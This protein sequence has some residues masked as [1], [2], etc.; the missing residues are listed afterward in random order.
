MPDTI[1]SVT[2][3]EN[4]LLAEAQ[5]IA[6]RLLEPN[7]ERVDRSGTVPFENLEALAAAGLVDGA[8]QSEAFRKA[9][10]EILCAAC[11]T[12]YFVLTQHLGSCGQIQQSAN[13]WL[14][15][16]FGVA[17]ATG[18]HYVGVGFGHLRRP[19]PML[20]ATP[21][22]GGWTLTG[23]APWVTGWPVLSGT[24]YG[25]HLPDGRHLYVYADA[26]VS[27]QQRISAPLPLCAMGATETVEV[28]LDQLFVPEENFVRYS[29]A[30]QLALSDT[31]N[32]CGNVSPMLGVARGSVSLLR[33][34]A[35]KK[36]FP[37]LHEAATA[38]ESQIDASRTH[39][40]QLAAADK[41]APGWRDKALTARAEAIELG[42][43][44]AH[45][46]VAAASGA[47]NGLDHPA[48]RRYRE[49]MFYTLFQQSSELLQGTV[50]H[51][52]R[53]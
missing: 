32:L 42:V 5:R 7:A 38:F 43:R 2:D 11:G 20:R 53:L 29:S 33:Q 35:L 28:T 17:M 51:L 49:A 34:L 45:A 6:D 19:Q 25:A 15:E 30:E 27:D 22:P 23:I 14:R 3:Q 1:V 21:V 10:V 13:P 50:R 16:R 41:S 8:R 26:T 37:I 18:R 12:T 40:D 31:L 4:A 48:Q 44:A 47:A 36:P 39:C 9:F 52:A 24:I 46:A